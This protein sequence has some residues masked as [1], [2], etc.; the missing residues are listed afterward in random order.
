MK[1]K[2]FPR[3]RLVF[4]LLA[5]ALLT[6]LMLSGLLSSVSYT[7]SDALY[8]QPQALDGNVL[9]IGIDD[10]AIDELGRFGDWGREVMAEA[11]EIL[12]ADPENRPAV[13]GL[14]VLFTGD[15]DPLSDARL[16]AAAALHGNVVTA[17]SAT[18]GA[19]L[20][21]NA[22]DGFYMDPF[23][24]MAYAEPYKA[25]LDASHQGHINAMMDKDGILRHA[26]FQIDLADG[27]SVP[28]FH[29]QLYRLYA[30]QQGLDPALSPPTNEQHFWYLPFQA[31]PGDYDEGISLVDLLAGTV[32]P[33]LFADKVVIIGPYT[34]G[35]QD[36][37]PTA[38]DHAQYMF[39]MEYQANA[40]DAM[41][42]GDFKTELPPLPQAI[43][44][45]C[46]SL[47]A[48]FCF[49][50][51]R[52]LIAVL[53]WLAFSMG[54]VLLA[55]LLYH[56][57][58]VVQLLYFPLSVTV[59]VIGG[60]VLNYLRAAM[61]KQV[62]TNT[63]KRYVA[64]EIVTE[65]LREGTDSLAL[66]GKL[67]DI[68]VLFVDIRGFTTLSER[69]APEQVVEILNRYLSLISH[70][71]LEN[72]G[73]LDK[74]IGDCA[75]AFWGAPLPQEDCIYKAVKSAM[76]MIEGVKA[77]S[78][79]TAQQ[80][81]REVSFG[82]GVHFGPA[83]VGNIG[84]ENRMDYTAIGDTVNTAARL[85]SNAPGGQIL[86]SRAVFEA[87]SGRVAFT[88]LGTEIKL[89]GK[90]ADF[91]IFRVDGLSAKEEGD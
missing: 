19:A 23:S 73:T 7:L 12:N 55:L 65:L 82:V 15:T 59:L 8:Q 32:P 57:G 85:E 29:Q 87:V 67:T 79:E 4:S 53:L 25:L 77:L 21:E 70:C 83:V 80:Y 44:L 2:P 71:I 63:F 5:A 90:S 60:V 46:V 10:R 6:A 68:A 58:Y 74:F 64:P 13:I 47:L 45:F 50:N 61:E 37:Y 17:T 52:P 22:D 72:G 69:L 43:L 49:W 28:S 76:E 81:G 3:K 1:N 89:K 39:G 11:L 66:G 51:R 36:Y 26:L 38:I 91:E 34:T 41:I 33:D 84:A 24:I 86:V 20:V 18:F 62:I 30:E 42:R 40:L 9:L 78:E 16:A 56:L 48:A 75:M 14:D 54:F 31:A 27:E 88:S 35:L